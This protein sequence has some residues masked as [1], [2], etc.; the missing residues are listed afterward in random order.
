[1]T[2]PRRTIGPPLRASVRVLGLYL[3]ATALVFLSQ[4]VCY[5]VGFGVAR[6]PEWPLMAIGCALLGLIPRIGSLIGI[7]LVLSISSLAG[8]DWLHLAIAAA[9][10]ISTLAIETFWLTPRLL[11]KPLGLKAIVVF[12]VLLGAGFL[13][14][15]IG[16]F[17]AVPALGIILV[18]IR[19][20][21]RKPLL[22]Q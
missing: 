14:G 1:M 8:V 17:F 10:W 7:A 4:T 5:L 18:W 9:A 2:P 12:A 16:L 19:F 11:G 6:L 21:R 20:F 3:K 22:P 15:P 13:A